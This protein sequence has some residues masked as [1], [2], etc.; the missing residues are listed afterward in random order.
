M[1]MYNDISK[2]VV[3]QG[4]LLEASRPFSEHI[5]AADRDRVR[6]RV[7]DP[8]AIDAWDL[9]GAAHAGMRTALLLRDERGRSAFPAPE[10]EIAD[11]R[12]LAVALG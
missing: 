12:E 10:V 6:E 5:E 8:G 9:P 4:K 2:T 1:T 3:C 11:L 7:L